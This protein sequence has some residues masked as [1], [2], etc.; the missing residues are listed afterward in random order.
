MQERKS[1]NYHAEPHPREYLRKV[2]YG[3][4]WWTDRITKTQIQL[5]ASGVQY[6][7]PSF[8]Q[9]LELGKPFTF[10]IAHPVK[11]KWRRIYSSKRGEELYISQYGE[12]L[13]TA[14][15]P[16]KITHLAT[17]SLSLYY[18]WLSLPQQLRAFLQNIEKGGE[19]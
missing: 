17:N 8:Q 7:A 19:N 3:D 2:A 16:N 5:T 12:K 10:F 1:W 4:Y 13:W 15:D 6:L 18:D 14:Y 9:A 11:A